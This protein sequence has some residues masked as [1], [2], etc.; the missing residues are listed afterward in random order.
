MFVLEYKI[1]IDKSIYIIVGLNKLISIDI[2]NVLNWSF[3]EEMMVESFFNTKI[4]NAWLEK[5]NT[6]K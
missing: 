4:P 2:F 5:K 1:Y 3:I 6:V